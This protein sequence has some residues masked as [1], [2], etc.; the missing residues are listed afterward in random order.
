MP[1]PCFPMPGPCF[2]IYHLFAEAEGRVPVM[3]H[4]ATDRRTMAVDVDAYIDA[5]GDDIRIVFLTNPHSPS[6]TWMTEGDVRRIVEAAPEALVVLDEAYVHYSGTGGYIHLVDE[7]PNLVVL[8]T[9]S[10]AFGLAGLRVGF[11]VGPKLVVDAC[12]AVKPTWNMGFRW[13]PLAVDRTRL[14]REWWFPSA[15]LTEEQSKLISEDWDNTAW[16]DFVIVESVQRGVSSRGY[17]PGPLIMDPSGICDVHSE[18]SVRH[19]QGLLL[20][21]LGDAV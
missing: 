17:R 5:I 14:I 19:L 18:N 20:A 4:E 15:E 2:P 9:F 21:V 11:G 13:V 7:Y 8:R 3:V 6:G 16:E 1:G 12:L 10:K